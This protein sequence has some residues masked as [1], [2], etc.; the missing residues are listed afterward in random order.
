MSQANPDSDS[1]APFFLRGYLPLTAPPTIT[2]TCCYL[3][4]PLLI[5]RAGG[6]ESRSIIMGTLLDFFQSY[7]ATRS[8]S[9][10]PQA[11]VS[12]KRDSSS[13]AAVWA[14]LFFRLETIDENLSAKPESL[15]RLH[16]HHVT[17][18]SYMFLFYCE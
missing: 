7:G 16:K 3:I 4:P 14:V 17:T 2:P 6:W 9:P 5:D 1:P 18:Y 13:V 8:R 10:V 12:G 15:P 11:A